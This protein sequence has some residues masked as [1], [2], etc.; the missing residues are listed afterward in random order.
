[1]YKYGTRADELTRPAAANLEVLHFCFNPKNTKKIVLLIGLSSSLEICIILPC[2][3]GKD[4][5]YKR[6]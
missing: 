2:Q 4:T 3:K 6:K 5:V 1:M